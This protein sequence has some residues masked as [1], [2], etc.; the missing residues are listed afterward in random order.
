MTGR[1]KKKRMVNLRGIELYWNKYRKEK[2]HKIVYRY[3][4]PA[5]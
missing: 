1:I 3:A 4:L 2:R 5:K